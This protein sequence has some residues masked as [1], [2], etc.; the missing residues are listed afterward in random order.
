MQYSPIHSQ[1]CKYGTR[2]R[3]RRETAR[4]CSDERRTCYCE[5]FFLRIIGL[6]KNNYLQISKELGLREK[7][8][9]ESLKDAEALKA[10]ELELKKLED[11]VAAYRMRKQDQRARFGAHIPA[12]LE[13]IGKESG[14]HRKPIGP[15]GSPYPIPPY[16]K[17]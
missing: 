17:P 10:K 13:A 16:F 11:H 1:C 14:W 15:L 6:N 3:D 2:S 5:Y 9:Y 4:T 7:H 8:L 12:L